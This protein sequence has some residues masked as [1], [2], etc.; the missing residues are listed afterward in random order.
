MVFRTSIRVIVVLLAVAALAF[1][2]PR[3]G[4]RGRI[5]AGRAGAGWAAID[6]MHKMPMDERRKVLDRLPPGRKQ[7]LERT[8][9]RYEKM[10]PRERERLRDHYEMFQQLPAERQDEMRRL[11]R[12]FNNLP[13]D[14]RSIIRQ[15]FGEMRSMSAEERQTRMN[16]SEF[17]NKYTVQEQRML[18]DMARIVP[19]QT[20][21]DEEKAPP[22]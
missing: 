18:D 8:L 1:G 22:E 21:A 2:Q 20:P 4:K 9:D 11:F 15:E 6:R 7:A 16:S 3:P 13:E 5:T 14:R 12:R 10:T 17:R 19:I